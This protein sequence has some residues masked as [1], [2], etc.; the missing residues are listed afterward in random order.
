MITQISEQL[1]TQMRQGVAHVQQVNTDFVAQ[2]Q[3]MPGHLL[4]VKQAEPQNAYV[5]DYRDIG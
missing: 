2:I 3:G 5:V 4:I 1:A